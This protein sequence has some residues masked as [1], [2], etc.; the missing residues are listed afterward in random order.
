MTSV[1][2]VDRHA[3]GLPVSSTSRAAPSRKSTS[4]FLR[5]SAIA[6]LLKGRCVHAT[7][8][9]PEALVE[10]GLL[11]RGGRPLR[12]AGGGRAGARRRG[13]AGG[14]RAGAGGRRGSRG[15]CGSRPAGRRACLVRS[16]RAVARWR[17]AGRWPGAGG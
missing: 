17:S 10:Y 6:I 14:G 4:N 9:S 13:G 3:I 15:T 8:G 7:R 5:V 12:G 11:G 1:D 16:W 2:R